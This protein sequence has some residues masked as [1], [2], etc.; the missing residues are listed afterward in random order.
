MGF[1]SKRYKTGFNYMDKKPDGHEAYFHA[2]FGLGLFIP[3]SQTYPFMIE[4]GLQF[5]AGSF[6][7]LK[8]DKG[9][10]ITVLGHSLQ[11]YKS[12]GLD[13]YYSPADALWS[14]QV[15]VK[16]NYVYNLTE[17]APYALA[18]G[19]SSDIL[20]KMATVVTHYMSEEKKKDIQELK[21][22]MK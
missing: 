3:I 22:I 2:G 20:L 7:Y 19:L 21:K 8:K 17:K 16:F 18:L 10:S 9:K 6:Q 1:S 11:N 12:V 5:R 14:M 4:T 15:P 13:E